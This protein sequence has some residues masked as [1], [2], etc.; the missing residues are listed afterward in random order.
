MNA[1]IQNT[2]ISIFHDNSSTRDFSSSCLTQKL[3]IN[4]VKG[5]VKV[6]SAFQGACYN[7]ISITHKLEI[8]LGAYTQKR[9]FLVAPLRSTDVILSIPFRPQTQSKY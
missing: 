4:I 7:V 5:D 3:N 1:S 9:S 8:T 2:P 6:K